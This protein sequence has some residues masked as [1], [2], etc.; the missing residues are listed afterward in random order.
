[1]GLDEDDETLPESRQ[2]LAGL[3]GVRVVVGPRPVCQAALFNQLARE[4][5]NEIVCLFCDDYV[6][7][8]E[9]WAEM[10]E[11]TIA[12]LPNGYGVGY[13]QDNR[14][15]KYFATF[16]FMTKKTFALN[17][18]GNF[19]P[20]MYPFLFGDTHW[21]EIAVMSGTILP[22]EVRVAMQEET[23]HLHR[24]VDLQLWAEL[25]HYMRPLR[26]QIAADL[27]RKAWG[28][29]PVGDQFIQT[30]PQRTEMLVRL[31]ASCMTPEFYERHDRKHGDKWLHPGYPEMKRNAE[32]YLARAREV[33][34]EMSRE[35]A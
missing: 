34:A 1:M 7:E 26:A 3:P 12:C 8:Q 28:Y 18:A 6:V 13:L 19:L 27:V 32:L 10:V 29:N 33:E 22:C 4:A 15:Y 21:N 17:Y 25:F 14:F 35:A 11:R 16:P 30:I 24:Y 31:H 23:A 2:L 20:Q 5:V 9:S